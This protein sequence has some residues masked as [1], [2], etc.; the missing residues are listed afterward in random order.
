MFFI[1]GFLG[2]T[3]KQINLGRE[4]IFWSH[5]AGDESES[6][7]WGEQIVEIYRQHSDPEET[8]LALYHQANKLMVAKDYTMATQLAHEA[9]SLLPEESAQ[10]KRCTRLL[11]HIAFLDR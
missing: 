2:E 9:L 5:R 1:Y 4:L 6:K 7:L 10:I 3:E 8:A 11:S